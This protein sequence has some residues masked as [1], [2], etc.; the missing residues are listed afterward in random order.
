MPRKF[1]LVPTTTEQSAEHDFRTTLYIK[2]FWAMNTTSIHTGAFKVVPLLN[3]HPVLLNII[4]K[5]NL[6]QIVF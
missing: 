2:K 5:L 1:E 6:L 4:S 3:Y